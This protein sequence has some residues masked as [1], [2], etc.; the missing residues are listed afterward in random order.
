MFGIASIDGGNNKLTDLLETQVE[1]PVQSKN[2]ILQSSMAKII[3]HLRA[4]RENGFSAKEL[5]H[6]LNGIVIDD[7]LAS[8]LQH[9][10]KIRTDEFGYWFRS[11][12]D[13]LTDQLSVLQE[14]NRRPVTYGR[15]GIP[16]ANLSD[17]Y[18]DI[19]SD[20]RSLIWNGEI[21]AV[22]NRVITEKST[23]TFFPRGPV[24]GTVL[25]EPNE[26][27]V[28]ASSIFPHQT[29]SS[30]SHV[31]DVDR[32]EIAT[33]CD[34]TKDIYPGE[35]VYLI[36]P[37]AAVG[38]S[39][40]PPRKVCRVSSSRIGGKELAEDT[41][42]ASLSFERVYSATLDKQLGSN[43]KSGVVWTRPITKR[44]LP[45]DFAPYSSSSSSSSSSFSS[46][47]GPVSIVRFGCSS[48]IRKL[49]KESGTKLPKS[50]DELKKMLNIKDEV[51]KVLKRPAAKQKKR[52]WRSAKS[53][54]N[55]HL[56]R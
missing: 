36:N 5:Q 42:S 7:D 1:A 51:K 35:A 32:S 21:I 34:L 13:H 28:S 49:W 17:C 6:A 19:I 3:D 55:A 50:N 23:A 47:T 12:N 33:W 43:L 15:A 22:E 24:F 31:F 8:A 45:L 26:K 44:T 52:A 53:T 2:V 54:T 4:N 38:D 27:L 46:S 20:M 29:S 14:I 9:H 56:D 18:K 37:T 48:D 39:Q 11:E 41:I 10:R 30:S 25:E 40:P 16:L